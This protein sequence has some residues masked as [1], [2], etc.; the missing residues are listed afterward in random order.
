MAVRVVTDSTSDITQADARALGITVVPLNIHAG[1]RQFRDGID[2][3][4]PEFFRRLAASKTLP[5][6][7]QPSAGAF[8][9]VYEALTKDTDEI[10][11]IHISGK[12]SGTLNSARAAQQELGPKARI[13]VLDSET[14]SVPLA[15]AARAAQDAATRGAGLAECAEA[16]RDTL[17]RTTLV[18]VLD[19][20]EY[21]QRGGRIGRAR[22]WLGAVFNVKPVLTV[23]DGEIAPLE[24]VRTRARAEERVFE[25]ATTDPDPERL[26]IAHSSSDEEGE[27]WAARLREARPGVPVEVGWLGPVVGVYGGPKVL[28][29]AVL[30]RTR[31]MA[32]TPEQQRA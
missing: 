23:K 13:E 31:G 19:T 6:T 2:I 3:T 21:L 9:E 20:L 24:R 10:L 30:H 12:L 26:A 17:A 22:A 32:A 29:M 1:T 27:R 4:P 7:S 28:G 5:K 11:S 14:V 25:L 18:Y 8:L 16:A 15:F